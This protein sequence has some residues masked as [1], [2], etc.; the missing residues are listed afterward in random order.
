MKRLAPLLLLMGVLFNGNHAFASQKPAKAWLLISEDLGELEA[1]RSYFFKKN[2]V[3]NLDQLKSM[4]HQRMDPLGFDVQIQTG[5]TA[6][7][8]REALDDPESQ[9][10]FWI[11]HASPTQTVEALAADGVILDA[12]GTNVGPLF[13]KIHPNFRWISIIGCNSDGLVKK[14]RSQGFYNDNTILHIEGIDGFAISSRDL[15]GTSTNAWIYLTTLKA[16]WPQNVCEYPRKPEKQG[17]LLTVRRAPGAQFQSTILLAQNEKYLGLLTSENNTTKIWIP[18]NL[19][20]QLI[21]AVQLNVKNSPPPLEELEISSEGETVKWVAI[22]DKNGKR[23]GDG[24]QVYRLEGNVK[25]I[26]FENHP[27]ICP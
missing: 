8:L 20:P 2:K 22:L 11:G 19:Q 23:M 26:P 1:G 5:A 6:A 4:F 27:P 24:R 13:K 7:Q 17:H 10:L 14:Y 16:Q 12:Q 15:S 3:S 21:E 25:D 18:Q 9:V